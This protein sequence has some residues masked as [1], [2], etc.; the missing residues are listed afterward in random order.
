[1]KRLYVWVRRVDGGI[2]LAGELAST[3]PVAGG[4]FESEFEYSADWARDP[5]AIPLDPIS[6]P[7]QPHGRRFHAEQLYPPLAVFDDA[8]PDDWGRRLL[9]KALTREGRTLSSPE[10]LLALRGAGT[11]ALVFTE[12][13]SPPQ[14]LCTVEMR[15][16]ATV[17][18]AASKF[19]AGTLPQDD[20]FRVLLEGSSRAGGARPKALVHDDEGEWIAKFPSRTRDAGHDVVGL[21]ATCLELARQAGLTVP[22]ARLRA[23]GRT[24]VLLVRRFDV[25]EGG[26]RFHM[27]SLRTLCRERPGVYVTTELPMDGNDPAGLSHRDERDAR[28]DV[29]GH[30]AIASARVP[31][32]NHSEHRSSYRQGDGT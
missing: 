11:G 29:R 20:D 3:D 28:R 16:L 2:T 1:M 19:E 5:T 22:E 15:S 6:L 21:E 13:P 31:G 9:A 30:P 12:T 27:V 32:Y 26:G 4:R 14:L 7:L 8:L 10:M 23:A 24:R 18:S 17:L 25:T